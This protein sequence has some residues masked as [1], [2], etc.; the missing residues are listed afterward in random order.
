[1]PVALANTVAPAYVAPAIVVPAIVAP[2]TRTAEAAQPESRPMPRKARNKG[3][4]ARGTRPRRAMRSP[5]ATTDAA[6]ATPA[7][8]ASMSFGASMLGK[9]GGKAALPPLPMLPLPTLTTAPAGSSTFGAG[10]LQQRRSPARVIVP[11]LAG[12]AAI[13]A[14][15]L[16][17]R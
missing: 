2:A 7:P 12:I 17:F 4:N 5:E 14:M 8:S 9:R 16:A 11:I 6:T 10:V 1:M 13:V 3:R 15:V